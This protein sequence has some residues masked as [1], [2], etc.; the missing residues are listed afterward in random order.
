MC[1]ESGGGDRGEVGCSECR[2]RRLGGRDEDGVGSSQGEETGGIWPVL[3]WN[4]GE[5]KGRAGSA[6]AGDG[7][8]CSAAL[9][10]L[11]SSFI[12]CTLLRFQNEAFLISDLGSGSIWV[13]LFVAS[14]FEGQKI[15]DRLGV[16]AIGTESVEDPD[17]SRAE[18]RTRLITG[19]DDKRS[20]L[21]AV[22]GLGVDDDEA[23]DV[24]F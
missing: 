17:S 4:I 7:C 6:G 18:L 3:P 23:F 2:L 10:G 14:L 20:G 9:C 5:F 15:V 24:V 13:A 22:D 12:D 1:C 16:A 11:G 21:G 19:L 8:L